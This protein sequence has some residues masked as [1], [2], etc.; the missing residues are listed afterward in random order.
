MSKGTC[1]AFSFMVLFLLYLLIVISTLSNT[2][3]LSE[4]RFYYILIISFVF[5]WLSKNKP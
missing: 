4:Y 1:L 3:V 5:L 2:L